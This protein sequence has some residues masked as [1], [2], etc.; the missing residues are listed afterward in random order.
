LNYHLFNELYSRL[1]DLYNFLSLFCQGKKIF[2]PPIFQFE[3]E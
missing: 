3:P 1:L 2:F